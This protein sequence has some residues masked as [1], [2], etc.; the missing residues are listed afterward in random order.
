MLIFSLIFHLDSSDD[1]DPKIK[2]QNKTPNTIFSKNNDSDNES[3]KVEYEDVS[4]IIL[5]NAVYLD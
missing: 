1:E 2:S 5:Y 4:S 3:T